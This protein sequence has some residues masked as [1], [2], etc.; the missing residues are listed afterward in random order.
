MARR[1]GLRKRKLKEQKQSQQ[2]SLAWWKIQN[3][4]SEEISTLPGDVVG[5]QG[6]DQ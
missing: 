2:I 5:P 6:Q 4:A 1:N 3:K